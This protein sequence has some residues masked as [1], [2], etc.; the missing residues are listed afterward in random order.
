M[1]TRKTVSYC[2]LA[3]AAIAHAAFAADFYVAPDGSNDNPGTKARPFATFA[4]AKAAARPIAGKAPVNVYFAPGTYYISRPIVFTAGDSGTKNTPVNYIAQEPLQSTLSG[5]VALDLK[6]KT[7]GGI[8]KA[9]VPAG[10]EFDQLFINGKKM[11]R[12][13]FPNSN[14]KNGFWDDGFRTENPGLV[15]IAEL[16]EHLAQMKDPAGAFVHGYHGIGWGSLHFQIVKKSPSGE[17][18]LECNEDENV[19]GG[20][21]NSGRKE[22]PYAPIGEKGFVEN[23]LEELD[24]PGEWFLDK[25]TATLHLIAPAGLDPRKARIEAVTQENL[26]TFDGA[27]KNAVKFVNIKGFR[28]THTAYTYMKTDAVPSGGD[29]RIYRGGAIFI[30]GAEDCQITDCFFDRTGGNAV[31]I[32]GYN[33]RIKVADSKFVYTGASCIAVEGLPSTLRSWWAHYWGWPDGLRGE[34]PVVNGEPY[35]SES[36]GFLPDEMLDGSHPLVDIRPGPKNNNCPSQCVIENNL[37]HDIGAVE[38]QVAGVF[39][40]KAFQIF[41]RHNTI[42]NCP[43]AAININ[44]NAWGGHILEYNEAFNTSMD[45]REHGCYNSWGRD[46]Y[47]RKNGVE[48]PELIKKYKSFALLDSLKPIIIRNNRFQ[49]AYGYDIDLDDGST[50]YEI[51]NN[52]CPQGGIKIREGFYRKVFNNISATLSPHSGNLENSDECYSNIL[53]GPNPYTPKGPSMVIPPFVDKNLITAPEL[54]KFNWP[55]HPENDAHSLYADAKFVDLKSGNFKLKSDSPAFGLGFKEFGLDSFGVQTPKLKA[56]AK[57][58]E[59]FD[60]FDPLHLVKET[61]GPT[62]GK[63]KDPAKKDAPLLTY[64]G[65]TLRTL[66]NFGN[67]SPKVRDMELDN[68]DGVLI[69]NVVKDSAAGRANVPA[70]CVILE[71]NGKRVNNLDEMVRIVKNEGKYGTITLKTLHFDE[72]IKVR[73]LKVNKTRFNRVQQ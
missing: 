70:E 54:E 41:L 36:F 39:I 67:E 28:I 22:D 12:A 35:T 59:G 2:I 61:H 10:I 11:V 72:G 37:M 17:Y 4:K 13:R 1:P 69:K 38:K 48:E 71:V 58:W 52:L 32:Y 6:W 63:T 34:L 18:T 45:S 68:N 51:Y 33:R 66:V 44:D 7:S 46:R 65:M 55:G 57:R 21:Q 8:H 15:S 19:I 64:V 25:K 26:I 16:K 5:A 3:V 73:T 49:C 62:A 47:W 56:Q 29:W 31:Y 27:E 23:A 30:S 42:Y 20:Y 43:R 40:S 9:K 60:N 24:A 53:I 50:N 14:P